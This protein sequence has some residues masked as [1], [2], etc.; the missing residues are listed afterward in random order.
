M[1]MRNSIHHDRGKVPRRQSSPQQFRDDGAGHYS[2]D[3]HR[4]PEYDQKG[5]QWDGSQSQPHHDNEDE[6]HST[7]KNKRSSFW[8]RPFPYRNF[9]RDETDDHP[10]M[11]R[12]DHSRRTCNSGQCNMEENEYPYDRHGS[13]QSHHHDFEDEDDLSPQHTQ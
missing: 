9:C 12:T 1:V 6:S 11:S 2:R 10:F 5:D 8:G 13:S 4:S 3:A 7:S